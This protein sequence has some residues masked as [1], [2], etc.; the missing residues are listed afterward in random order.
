MV[1]DALPPD[2]VFPAMA[3]PQTATVFAARRRPAV[4][5]AWCGTAAAVVGWLVGWHTSVVPLQVVFGWLAVISPWFALYGMFRLVHL[6]R[7]GRVLNTAPW[8]GRTSSYRLAA[9]TGPAL[10]IHADYH[11]PEAVCPIVQNKFKPPV[12]EEG[13]R[14]RLWVAGDPTRWAVVAPPD[15]SKLLVARPPVLALSATRLRRAA[16]TEPPPSP[17][18]RPDDPRPMWRRLAATG[19]GAF[20]GGLFAVLFVL[21]V[22]IDGEQAGHGVPLGVGSAFLVLAAVA[23]LW[24]SR[25]LA[26][27][28]TTDQETEA[29]AAVFLLTLPVF[30]IGAAF[31][32]GG[33]A[34]RLL[35]S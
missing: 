15:R 2:G 34:G 3:D 14:R 21:A 27:V 22:Y 4:R 24:L 17:L 23:R 19:R 29:K 35:H 10:V 18:L 28:A 31:A 32:F 9:S 11:G 16:T 26:R 8:V 1:N 33:L 5:S 6:R 12:F 20:F 25:R 7:I 30:L 13:D